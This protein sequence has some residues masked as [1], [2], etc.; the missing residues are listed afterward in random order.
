MR[1]PLATFLPRRTA[2]ADL[3]VVQ[4]AVGARADDDL[5]DLDTLHLADGHTLSTVCGLA[6][7]GSSRATSISM[8]CFV[9][10]VGVRERPAR[11]ASV[12]PA[13]SRR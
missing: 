2:A 3:Q 5:V 4:P 7:C 1:V 8:I 11:S 12:T 6:T 10:G 13:S 9:D